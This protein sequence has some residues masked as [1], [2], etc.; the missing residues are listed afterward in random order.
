MCTH[1]FPYLKFQYCTL[2]IIRHQLHRLDNFPSSTPIRY[3]SHRRGIRHALGALLPIPCATF[4]STSTPSN[5]PDINVDYLHRQSP[6][7]RAPLLSTI[8][9]SIRTSSR[10]RKYRSPKSSMNCCRRQNAHI[11]TQRMFELSFT[12]S[13][14]EAEDEI[15]SYSW[16]FSIGFMSG[17]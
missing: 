10:R 15:V 4:S 14:L 7:P 9:P 6:A 13:S 17:C 8:T 16:R 12:L 1:T 3:C 2:P 5:Y 11:H